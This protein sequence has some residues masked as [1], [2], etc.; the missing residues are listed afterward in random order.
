MVVFFIDLFYCYQS[1]L[2]ILACAKAGFELIVKETLVDFDF[3]LV[4]HVGFVKH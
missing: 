2:Q 4:V 1:T 3:T